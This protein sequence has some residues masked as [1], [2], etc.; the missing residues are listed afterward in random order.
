VGFVTLPAA[1]VG[2]VLAAYLLDGVVSLGTIV[3]FL[4]V[5]GIVA[6]DRIMLICH[7]Q[8]FERVEGEPFGVGLVIRRARA[9]ISPILMTAWATGLALVPLLVAGTTPG[10]EIAHPMAVV[11]LGGLITSTTLDLFVMP[12]LYLRFARK[13]QVAA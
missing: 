12:A 2:G 9:R 10:H 5:L 7:Y 13:S 8:Q 4:T 11:I 6:R 1:L 3:G